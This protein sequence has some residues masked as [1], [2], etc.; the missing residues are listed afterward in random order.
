MYRGVC[1]RS[2]RCSGPF[3]LHQCTGVCTGGGPRKYW[4]CVFHQCTGVC[5][6][7]GPRKY[8][9]CVFHLYRGVC[10]RASEQECLIVAWQKLVLSGDEFFELLPCRTMWHVRHCG[11]HPDTFTNP[12][13]TILS[14][15]IPSKPQQQSLTTTPRM[16][17]FTESTFEF[18]ADTTRDIRALFRTYMISMPELRCVAPIT[19]RHLPVTPKPPTGRTKLLWF[20]DSD[21]GGMSVISIEK[22]RVPVLS[23]GL[24]ALHTY[25]QQETQ[26]PFTLKR[27]GCFS[28]Q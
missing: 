13:P 18:P 8:W 7:R 6:G 17:D 2:T 23:W 14:S 16:D 21:I 1:P 20:G 26:I 22:V 27:L 10:P 24:P 12:P 25:K 3:V 5:T 28:C 15:M 9:S 11:S 19:Q 4:S